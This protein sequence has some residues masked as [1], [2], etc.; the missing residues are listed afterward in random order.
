MEDETD[1]SKVSAKL[2]KQFKNRLEINIKYGSDM[3]NR[4][5]EL[6]GFGKWRDFQLNEV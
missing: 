1:L 6:I 3:E 5:I 4:K 2:E